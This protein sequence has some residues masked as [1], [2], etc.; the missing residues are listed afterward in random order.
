MQD[1]NGQPV[2]LGSGFFVADGVVATNL[3]VVRGASSG[4]AKLVGQK[5]TYPVRGVVGVNAGA[6]I[7][8]LEVAGAKAPALELSQAKDLAVGDV[9]YA[10]GNPE[11]LEGTFSQGVV[12]GF[13]G[14]GP[15]KLL[16]ITA[17]ISPG[18]SGG[19]IINSR[20]E[21]V[22]I[23]VATFKEGQNL[24]FAVPASYVVP[25]LKDMGKPRP[26]SSEG[27]LHNTARS[28]PLFGSEGTEGV[29][30]TDFQW[31]GI[32]SAS[33]SLLC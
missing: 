31:I 26:L 2:S 22:G 18:S 12:S 15:D 21:V 24:N 17:P 25:L 16:Q 27:E 5:G 4:N 23:A 9:V 33:I 28:A 6:D 19:P 32:G 11:G 20:G 3:H 7:V 1:T 13:R 10:I 29:V 30:G 14:S 8:L